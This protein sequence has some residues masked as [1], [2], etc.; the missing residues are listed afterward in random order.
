MSAYMP[1]GMC[2]DPESHEATTLSHTLVPSKRFGPDLHLGWGGIVLENS[3]VLMSRG[4]GWR[5]Q[6]V[7]AARCEGHPSFSQQGGPG[8]AAALTNGSSYAQELEQM[9]RRCWSLLGTN[10]VRLCILVWRAGNAGKKS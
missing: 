7:H 2:V 8:W 5:T 6:T 9:E 3:I 4:C 10:P 1:P